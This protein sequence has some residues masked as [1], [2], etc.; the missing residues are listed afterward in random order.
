[1]GIVDK[2]KGIFGKSEVIGIDELSAKQD[3]VNI[4]KS[5]VDDLVKCIDENEQ[6]FNSMKSHTNDTLEKGEGRDKLMSRLEEKYLSTKSHLLKSLGEKKTSLRKCKE[7]LTTALSDSLEKGI[8][9]MTYADSIVRNDKGDILMLLRCAD[10]EFEP[11]KWGLPG[12]KIESG[13]TPREACVRELKEETNLDYDNCYKVGTKSLPNGGMITYYSVYIKNSTEWIG[14]D[15]EEHCNYCFM[16]LEEIRRRPSSAFIK[17]AKSTI[18][19]MVDPMYEA[20]ET[21]KKGHDSGKIDND[22][23]IKAI[24]SFDSFKFD[25]EA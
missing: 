14:L 10:D 3:K 21:I 9:S 7:E 12:G 6:S 1:M 8:G 16:S 2:I 11:N 18:L 17:D 24:S 20:M 22:T 19:K 23:M 4:I 25:K 13:E 5:E 15:S